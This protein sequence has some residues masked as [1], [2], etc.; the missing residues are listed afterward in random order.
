MSHAGK[1]ARQGFVVVIAL[2]SM[3]LS[4]CGSHLSRGELEA[5]NGSL[6]GLRTSSGR[7]ASGA[8]TDET[9]TGASAD[10]S[11]GTA[12]G[13]SGSGT[14]A[15]SGKGAAGSAG[16]AASGGGAGASAGTNKPEILLGSFGA[17]SGVLGAVSG[18]APPAIRAWVPYINSHG[19]IN[20]HPVRV[21]Q[22][23][24]GADPSRSQSIVR[25]MVEEDKVVAFFSTYSFTTSAVLPYL[26]QKKVPILGTI[27]ADAGED[28]SPMVF[29]PELGSD[30]GNAWSFI[31]PL[32]EAMPPDKRKV[33]ILYCREAAVCAAQKD[34]FAKLLPFKGLTVVYEAEASLAQPDYTAEVL[35]ARNA[36]ADIIANLLDSA[37][38]IRVAQ[39]V[40]RQQG[41][42]PVLSGSHNL[43]QDLLLQGGDR[44]KGTIIAS[45][46]PAYHTSPL[47]K[48]YRDAMAQYQPRGTKGSLGAGT[49]SAGKL[50]ADVI[51]KGLPDGQV[52][53]A[54]F[55]KALLTTVKNETLGGLYPGITFGEA[56]EGR[57]YTNLCVV[58]IVFDGKTFNP[59]NPQSTFK[60]PPGW[61]TG[62]P[63]G[64]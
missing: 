43:D 49:F 54:D 44:L 63:A 55:L 16:R 40:E 46:Q 64:G 37:S 28:H 58:T 35:G 23:D 11:A 61:T 6:V 51:G 48:F 52:T 5:A 22:A 39:A 2:A 57:P 41:Y 13:A 60:C 31:S 3:V 18:P 15:S 53:S 14:A 27:G 21:I 24:D 12:T 29:K 42:R 45:R 1:G 4:A 34:Q 36:G 59:F 17:E 9:A 20:G 10:G 25:K 30:E 26:E 56:P 62:K 50:L 38:V 19:G 8:V 32:D 33:A 47:L 7:D